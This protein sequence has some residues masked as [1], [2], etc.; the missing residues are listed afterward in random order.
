[1]NTDPNIIEI[2]NI[3]HEVS[4]LPWGV[5]YFYLIGISYGAFL[6]TL[7]AFVFGRKNLEKTGR[8]A[9]L[10]AITCGIAAPVAL[11]SDLHQPARF[12][13]F[14]LH[15]TPHSWM[16]WGSL[17]LPIYVFLLIVYSWL[18]YREDL[19]IQADSRRGLMSSVSRLLAAGGGK[20]P[21]LIRTVGYL[22][23]LS[24]IMVATY[25]G[26]EM[27]VVRARPLW[28][29]LMMPVMFV[30]TGISGA[31]GLGLLLNR[32][33]S[34]GDEVVTSQLNHLLMMVLGLSA[35]SVLFWIS[36][37][38]VTGNVSGQELMRLASDYN[39]W[40]FG[41]WF[42]LGILLP[43]LLVINLPARSWWLS[44]GL[45]MA[46][47][48]LFRWSMFIDAQRIPKTG[49]GFNVYSVPIG[50]E[51]LLGIVGTL[52]LWW[53]LVVLIVSVIPWQGSSRL[54]NN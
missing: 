5:Q 14:Y 37:G 39:P 11:V 27:A 41:L 33:V 1:M 28:H 21:G 9:L 18:I 7:P 54:G 19:A 20:A 15:F 34:D 47:A 35:L 36:W 43:F 51:G 24:A 25:T 50:T 29:G 13:N 42:G 26:A 32:I 31:A 38:V 8:L 22:V 44:G 2:I 12:Y 23:L 17:F 3:T 48:W 4:W 30:L 6:L 46:G 45:A 53:L 49:A 10:I 40:L 52:G 16:S